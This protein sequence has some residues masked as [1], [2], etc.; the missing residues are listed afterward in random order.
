MKNIFK[1]VS[2]L[3]LIAA[4]C[5]A[6]GAVSCKKEKTQPPQALEISFEKASYTITPGE[7]LEISFTVAN[8][9]T[10]ELKGSV[11]SSDATNYPAVLSDIED[12]AGIITVTAPAIVL[13]EVSVTITLDVKDEATSRETSKGVSV[14]SEESAV[15][16]AAGKANSFI[17]PPGSLFKFSAFEGNSATE[18]SFASVALVWQDTKGL[19]EG[20]IPDATAGTIIV[21][22]AEGVS[23][24]ALVAAKDAAGVILW[25]WHIWVTDFTPTTNSMVWTSGTD[26]AVTYT[27]MDRHLG[28]TSNTVKDVSS[29][30]LMYNWGRPTPFAAAS[31][32]NAL[33]DVYDM[34]G[35]VVPRTITANPATTETPSNIQNAIQNPTVHFTGNST[36]NYSWIGYDK[37]FVNAQDMWGMTA[38]TK[39]K[40]DPCPTGWKVPL[41]AAW[42]IWSDT[43][44]TKTKVFT[45]TET[46]AN[47]DFRGHTLTVGSNTYWFPAAGEIVVAGTFGSGIGGTSTWPCGKVWSATWEAANTRAFATSISP[48]S[49][50]A[51]GG[52]TSNYGL[53]V[54]CIA[55]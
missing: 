3:A 20:F 8:A 2:S 50:S 11:T 9:G 48:T 55:E 23:G 15:V 13:D 31:Y 38:G 32:E 42:A 51:S 18:V 41:I 10:A 45:T 44:V 7:D 29:N 12:G 46:T 35:E 19:V 43:N 22:L 1:S 4:M 49:T 24:N 39:S 27:F 52:I 37:T 30:G 6:L 14:V 36:N 54:R 34:D 28:A 16:T 33:K 5:L 47:A 21:R 40:Y 17:A 53:P 25:S 26:P